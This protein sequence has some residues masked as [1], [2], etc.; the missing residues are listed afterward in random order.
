MIQY[1]QG[2]LI[3]I[4]FKANEL[5]EAHTTVQLPD[6]YSYER[7]IIHDLMNIREL[8]PYQSVHVGDR[9]TFPPVNSK[10]PTI[11]HLY[12]PDLTKPAEIRLSIEKFGQI[13]DPHYFDKSFNPIIVKGD[14]GNNYNVIPSDQFK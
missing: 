8:C 5:S 12:I 9:I 11:L 1:Y 6:G 2:P 14:D 13:P 7:L 3:Y 10:S 4:A